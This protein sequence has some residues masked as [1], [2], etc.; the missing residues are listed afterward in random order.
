L[1]SLE[2]VAGGMPPGE[3]LLTRRQLEILRLLGDGL[4]AEAMSRRLGIS[5]RTVTKHQERLYRRL[6]TSDRLNSVL[7]AQRLGLLPPPGRT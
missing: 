2:R 3:P 1:T 6:G 4:S 7:R 5:R